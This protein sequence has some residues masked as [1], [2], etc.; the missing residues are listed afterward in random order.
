[1]SEPNEQAKKSSG[2]MGLIRAI[3]IVSVLV[4]VEMVGAAM[5]IPSAED[6]E[7]LAR[8]LVKSA[9]GE[10]AAIAENTEEAALSPDEKTIEVILLSDS[11]TRFNPETDATLNVQFTVYGVV[12]DEENELFIEHFEA[13]KSRIHE[14]VMLTMHGASTADLANAGLGL[15]KRQI[16]EKTNRTLGRPL[17]REVGFTKVNFIER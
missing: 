1:M 2:M 4:V 7:Q 10:E 13:N 12:L 16:L 9:S 15:I 3:V 11:I 6:T 17:L 5:M 8:E 14:Q